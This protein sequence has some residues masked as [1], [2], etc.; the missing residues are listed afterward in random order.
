M[1][2]LPGNYPVMTVTLT[3]DSS[4]ADELDIGEWYSTHGEF[5]ARVIERLTGD[6]PHVDDLLQETFIVAFNSRSKY[7]ERRAQPTTWLYSIAANLCKR[8][9]RGS[10]RFWR[11]KKELAHS[12]TDRD[13]G[14]LPDRDL[15]RQQEAALV[16]QVLGRLPFKQREVFV[17]YELEGMDG[18]AISEMVGI[19][20][21]TV[22]T[23]LHHARK[24]FTQLA[25][26]RLA[27][28]AMS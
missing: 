6:G 3:L 17:L 28:E 10:W 27:E 7:D 24:S 20:L 9:T 13:L 23:R 19:P 14:P 2:G 25:R 22:W 1:K 8:H 15:E 11:L 4:S 12:E 16:H 21:G 18:Q 26:H 5:V